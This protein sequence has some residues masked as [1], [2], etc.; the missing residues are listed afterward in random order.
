[1]LQIEAD[2]VRP[3]DYLRLS[4]EG[5]RV[6]ECL[7]VS[8]TPTRLTIEMGRFEVVFRPWLP[9]DG[10]IGPWPARAKRWTSMEVRGA[11]TD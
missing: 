5:D 11:Y 8:W 10:R 3:G 4:H 2:K 1:M 9:T 6:E 7:V